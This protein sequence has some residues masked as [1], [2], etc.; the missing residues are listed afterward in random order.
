[1]MGDYLQVE[2]QGDSPITFIPPSMYG[3]PEFVHVDWKD[4]ADPG[5]V[6]KNIGQGKV[7]WLPWD[8]GV[9]TTGTAQKRTPGS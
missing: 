8:L 1:M 5:L 7:A 9:S 6:M 3:P 4:T 2:P